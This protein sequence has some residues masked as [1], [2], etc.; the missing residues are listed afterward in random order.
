M[1]P[2]LNKLI[3]ALQLLLSIDSIVMIRENQLEND[4]LQKVDNLKKSLVN[5]ASNPEQLSDLP[6]IEMSSIATPK[7]KKE[8][9][10]EHIGKNSLTEQMTITERQATKNPVKMQRFINNPAHPFNKILPILTNLAEIKKSAEKLAKLTKLNQNTQNPASK[11]KLANKKKLAEVAKKK[12]Y[13]GASFSSIDDDNFSKQPT[14]AP[15]IDD[16]FSKQPTVGQTSSTLAPGYL[17]SHRQKSLGS[18]DFQRLYTELE[19]Q[20]ELKARLN[21]N[22]GR[23]WHERGDSVDNQSHLAIHFESNPII[24][25]N[26]NPTPR[27]DS[28]GATF[29]TF[30]RPEVNDSHL[31]IKKVT[32]TPPSRHKK[33]AVIVNPLPAIT[34]KPKSLSKKRKQDRHNTS[35]HEVV[36][37]NPAPKKKNKCWVI[38]QSL[39]QLH[40][41]PHQ[42]S[43]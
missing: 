2:V 40:Q 37:P 39:K 6:R 1:K 30:H 33:P 5:N 32:V 43:V 14:V 8:R 42:N 12:N 31:D 10:I 4:Y 23:E 11:T 19:T 34:S 27:K 28:L 7:I 26:F 38:L 15:I 18:D 9:I 41:I 17:N 29:F 20:S 3:I 22:I 35:I 16:G 25:R 36:P 24:S 13:G 21:N